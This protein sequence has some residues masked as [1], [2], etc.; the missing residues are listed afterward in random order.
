[1]ILGHAC[2]ANVGVEVSQARSSLEGMDG[3]DRPVRHVQN[4]TWSAHDEDLPG[5]SIGPRPLMP[6]CD[7]DRAGLKLTPDKV[8]D[9]PAASH[10]PCVPNV[11]PRAGSLSNQIIASSSCQLPSFPCPPPPSPPSITLMYSW[12]LARHRIQ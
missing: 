4:S 7:S 1:M 6:D 5:T 8:R 11:A 9:I 12:S 3:R 10:P 2:D